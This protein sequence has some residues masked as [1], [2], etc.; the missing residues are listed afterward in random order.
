MK[1]YLLLAIIF[2][3]FTAA[4]QDQKTVPV[5]KAV[6]QPAA[7]AAKTTAPASGANTIADMGAPSAEMMAVISNPAFVDA[8]SNPAFVDVMSNPELID[9]LANP[10]FIDLLS[11]K[12]EEVN[13]RLTAM[14]T[15]AQSGAQI[16]EV[17]PM[18]AAMQEQ[19]ERA[20]AATATPKKR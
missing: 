8:M 2:I 12:P 18:M 9:L 14:Q 5:S 6:S 20:A 7:T 17:A 4:K 11:G 15:M 13:A 10:G 1:N 3:A 19:N 16:A